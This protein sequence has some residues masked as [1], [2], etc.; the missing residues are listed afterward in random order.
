MGCDIHLLVEYDTASVREHWGFILSSERR[1]VVPFRQDV[2]ILSL[3]NGTIEIAR[4]YRLF[5]ALAGVR[6]NISPLIPPRGC[7]SPYS[8]E[9][10]CEFHLLVQDRSDGDSLWERGIWREDA[11]MLIDRGKA[12]RVSRAPGLCDAITDPEYHNLSWLNR[13]E[14]LASLEYAELD[15]AKLGVEFRIVLDALRALDDEYGSGHSRIVFGFD[16]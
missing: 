9:T 4:D 8:R 12:S 7:P 5:A 13:L 10:F 15:P 14:L 2:D 16:N 3:T 6:G 1:T 11:E